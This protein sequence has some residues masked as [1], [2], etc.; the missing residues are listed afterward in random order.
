MRTIARAKAGFYPTP[1]P[2]TRAIA[3]LIQNPSG[4]SGRL[5]DPCCGLG[6]PA[7]ALAQSLGLVSFGIE[8]D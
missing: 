4:H 8:L 7:R 5:C 3:E 1:E 6:Q 2:V